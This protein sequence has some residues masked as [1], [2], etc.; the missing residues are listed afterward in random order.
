[1]EAEA[2]W[3]VCSTSVARIVNG[4]TVL[5]QFAVPCDSGMICAHAS[6]EPV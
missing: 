4:K 3:K 6:K 5:G 2:N 1:M